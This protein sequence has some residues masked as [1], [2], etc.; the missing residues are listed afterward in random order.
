MDGGGT[1]QSAFLFA[2]SR[3]DLL[4]ILQALSDVVESIL[5]A[6]YV[7]DDFSAE[8]AEAFFD[9]IM[10]P[11]YDKHIS[12]YNLSH[13]PTK[14]LFELLQSQG[15]QKFEITKEHIDSDKNEVS[16][17]CEGA[18]LCLIKAIY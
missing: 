6:V 15:C 3:I 18:F 13:H 5:G 10:R 4:T 2:Y 14:I 9:K 16:V 7:S 12:L 1:T 8:G 17:K 11:F